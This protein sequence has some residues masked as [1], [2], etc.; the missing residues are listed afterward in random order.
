MYGGGGEGGEKGEGGASARTKTIYTN[1]PHSLP[2]SQA[3]TTCYLCF[4]C[5][6]S[7]SNDDDEDDENNP[8]NDPNSERNAN[9]S[10]ADDSLFES[11]HNNF[12]STPGEG[13]FSSSENSSARQSHDIQGGVKVNMGGNEDPLLLGGHVGGEDNMPQWAMEEVSLGPARSEATNWEC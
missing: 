2:P 11:R 5:F 12:M 3:S 13:G 7:A 1:S 6:K 8:N 4:C 10:M 9:R